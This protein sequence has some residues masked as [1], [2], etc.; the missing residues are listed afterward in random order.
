MGTIALA[1]TRFSF[2][3]R[4]LR[5]M[6]EP[7]FRTAVVLFLAVAAS[8]TIGLVPSDLSASA[9]LALAVSI[10]ALI[11]WVL[12]PLPETLVALAAALVFVLAGVLPA[13]RLY[14]TL[15]T[16]LVWLLI[17]AFVIAA[18]VRECGLVERLVAPFLARQPT[19][20]GLFWALTLLVASTALVLPSTSGRA[21]LF[22]PLFSSLAAILPDPR[23][24]RPLALLFPTAILL[25]AGGSLIGAGAHLIAV[26]AIVRSGGPQLSYL[27]WL[28]IAGPP[29]L[30]V[31]AAGTALILATVPPDLRRA[32]VAAIASRAPAD[33]RQRA[34]LVVLLALVV[35]WLC[36]PLHGIGSAVVALVGA[37]VL[38][39]PPLAARKPKEV[40]KQVDLELLLFLAATLVIAEAMAASGA[41]RWFANRAFAGLSSELIANGVLT[42]VLTTT[43]AVL[44]HLLV[45]SRSAR[46][47]ILV[48]TLALPAAG[49]GQ[50]VTVMV[51]LVTL[52][53][54]FCQTLP[55]SAKPV[56]IFAA[57][58]NS[59]TVH[60]LIRLAVPLA[61]IKI[62]VLSVFALFVWPLQ[63]NEAQVAQKAPAAASASVLSAVQPQQLPAA[64]PAFALPPHEP[65][66]AR[67]SAASSPAPASPATLSARANAGSARSATRPQ[68]PS[69][70]KGTG[71]SPTDRARPPKHGA[72]SERPAPVSV[73]VPP[74]S[75]ALW[76]VGSLAA[77]GSSDA[78]LPISP[79]R[80]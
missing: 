64:E 9:R 30:L 45:T 62:A 76:F 21:A 28:L 57:Q 42:V 73:A 7:G 10:V 16:E 24:R 8:L 68:R 44:A 18:A 33:P 1:H 15:G 22:V 55:A 32:R 58:E 40:L 52:G 72:S 59:F 65:A 66:S 49:L 34:V 60:D 69:T 43:V 31:T 63:L 19:V 39:L 23:L 36:E 41:D 54:G 56:A 48:P 70:A 4:R 2:S 61:P 29:A 12:T 74:P 79:V 47:A 11:G 67:E 75:A 27:D 46:A 78:Q 14:A 50:D 26:E 80:D 5:L 6:A 71:A 37:V 53:S 3:L 25:S 38:L 20:A 51:L 77:G 13:E 35:L 17:A